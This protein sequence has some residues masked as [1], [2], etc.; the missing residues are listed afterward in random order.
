MR[1]WYEVVSVESIDSPALLV[2]P[3]RI[4]F[5]IR[6]VKKMVNEDTQR[7]RPHVKTN[8][9]IEVCKM[10]IA[11]GIEQFKCSTIAEA[12]M[13]ALSDAKDV[14]MAYQPV[15][16]KIDRWLTLVQKYPKTH[17]SCLLDNEFS[18]KELSSKAKD[19][20]ITL[21]IY[22]DIDLGMGRT[23]ASPDQIER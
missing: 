11:A 8:K 14:L 3:D 10:M 15:G 1:N 12:E 17:F 6:L 7:L 21:S 19:R 2:Y 13:L 22:L 18:I 20:E 9:I 23:G 5:N 16:P 4:A